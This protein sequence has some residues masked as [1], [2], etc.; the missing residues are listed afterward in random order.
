MPRNSGGTGA[1]PPALWNPSCLSEDTT[2]GLSH[3]LSGP[4]HSGRVT[5][6]VEERQETTWGLLRTNSVNELSG[7]GTEGGAPVGAGMMEGDLQGSGRLCDISGGWGCDQKELHMR[8][9]G[10]VSLQ[11]ASSD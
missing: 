2:A 7:C 8:G 5:S 6:P 11:L 9:T 1:I 4:L 3:K 10:I